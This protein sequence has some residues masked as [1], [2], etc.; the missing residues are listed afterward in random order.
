[1]KAASYPSSSGV[2]RPRGRPAVTHDNRRVQAFMGAFDSVLSLTAE[3]PQLES[4]F[5]GVV[6]LQP[7]GRG[8]TRPL[9]KLQLFRVLQGCD[10][11]NT[12]RVIQAMG[13]ERADSSVYRYAALARVASKATERL[14][15]GHPEWEPEA[16]LRKASRE[17]LDA[18]YL[19]E[20]RAAGLV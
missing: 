1:M 4:L 14:L 20:L 10:H 18:P 17:E 12:D 7:E 8:S 5:T 15:T 9:S 16:A 2:T 13:R 11:L 19:A 3:H 6:H